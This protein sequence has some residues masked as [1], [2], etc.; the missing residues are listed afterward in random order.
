[1]TT[2]IFGN[3]SILNKPMDTMDACLVLLSV[4]S[5]GLFD[6][7]TTLMA[8]NTVGIMY[9]SNSLV[10]YLYNIEGTGGLFA[11]FKIIVVLVAVFGLLLLGYRRYALMGVALAGLYVGASNLT[12]ATGG[13]SFPIPGVVALAFV[14]GGVLSDY[15]GSR[16]V[17]VV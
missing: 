11:V 14:V 12:V 15:F 9:E 17:G 2:K 7:V 5:F 10:Q 8:A 4:L 3:S 13:S 16:R 6:A 1:M